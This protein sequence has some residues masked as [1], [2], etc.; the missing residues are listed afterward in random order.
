[1][2]FKT[3]NILMARF[4]L[5]TKG[6]LICRR[7]DG[8]TIGHL[9]DGG[10]F[11]NTGIESLLHLFHQI[12]PVIKKIKDSSQVAIE[13]HIVFIQNS[14]NKINSSTVKAATFFYG[15]TT[16]FQSFY[17]PWNNG[18]QTRNNMYQNLLKQQ[19]KY[20]CISL[21]SLNTIGTIPLGWYLSPKTVDRIKA[22]AKRRVNVTQY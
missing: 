7:S 19:I 10:Y 4:P 9:T 12:K 16:I 13:P 3:A 22:I 11:E 15:T 14:S 18:T 8:S 20:S 17:Q 1:M 5:I 6:G 21:D 2:P